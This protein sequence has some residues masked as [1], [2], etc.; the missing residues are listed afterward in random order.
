MISVIVPTFNRLE[1]LE[2]CLSALEVQTYREFE[3]VVAVDGST[4]GSVTL[5]ESVKRRAPFALTVLVLPHGGRSK[6]RNAAM[7]EAKGD[8]LVFCDDDVTLDRETLSRHAA[9]HDLFKRSAAIGP[10]SFPDGQTRFPKRPG[11]V[12]WSGCNASV[13]RDAA[14]EA[15]LFDETLGGY[16]GE[17]LEFGYRLE[18]SGVKFR[19]LPDAGAFHH[20]ARVP[21]VEKA[22]S[23]GYQAVMIAKKHGSG[24]T[25]VC[26]RSKACT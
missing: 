2:R 17:D 16:G 5:L 21:G 8:V 23:A 11:W 6:A 3:V 12:N 15:G 10:L 4:D 20:G 1:L 26:W 18:K 9:F 13:P 7:L 25:R 24:C 22:R 19:G 14:L